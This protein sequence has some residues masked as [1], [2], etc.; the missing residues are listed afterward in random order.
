MKNPKVGLALGSGGAR[1]FAHIGVLKSLHRAGIPIDMIAGSSM[2]ALVGAF[3]CTGHEPDTMVKMARM[4][5]RRYYMDY[6]VP[7]MG[8]V[9]GNK[10]EQLMYVLTQNKKIEDLEIPFSVIATDLLKSEKVIIREGLISEAVRAS[11]AVPGIFVPFK[12]DGRLLVDGSVIDRVPVSVVRE[13]GADVTIAVDISHIK[14]N[15]EINT[16]FDVIMQSIDIM[17]RELV[18]THELVTDVLIRPHVENFSASAFKDIEEIIEIG[19][20]ETNKRIDDIEAAI[21]NWRKENEKT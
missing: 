4:F 2:G 10:V 20:K 5:R 7:K 9:S 19:E 18:K 6:T 11:I 17:Q 1:G 16:I 12:K 8:F 14:Q 15:P 21:Q 3:Y 13:M